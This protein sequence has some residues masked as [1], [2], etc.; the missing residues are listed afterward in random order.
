MP[1]DRSRPR[2]RPLQTLC[3]AIWRIEHD[4]GLLQRKVA[5]VYY[6]PLIRAR[7]IDVLSQRLGFMDL[8][9][10]QLRRSLPVAFLREIS[11]AADDLALSPWSLNG[12]FDTIVV[13]FGRKHLR[14]GRLVDGYSDRVFR[15]TEFGR[16]LVLDGRA[17][18]GYPLQRYS[19]VLPHELRSRDLLRTLALALA[20]VRLPRIAA[21]ASRELAVIGEGLRKELSIP[22][23]MSVAHFALRIAT[24]LEGRALWTSV[25]AKSGARIVFFTGSHTLTGVAAAALDLGLKTVEFQHGL[26]S[27]YQGTYHYPGRP[28][29][30]YAPERLLTFG[31]YWADGLD[32]PANTISTPIGVEDRA[33]GA[34]SARITRRVLIPSQWSIGRKLFELVRDTAR[35][36]PDWEFVYRPHPLDNPAFYR[37][38]LASR[39][40]SPPNLRLSPIEEDIYTLMESSEVQIGL[41][42]TA[43][44]EGMTLGLRTIIVDLPGVENLDRVLANGDAVLARDADDI[45]AAL[46]TAPVARR[47]ERYFEAPVPSIA[48]VVA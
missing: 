25:L 47:P 29:V 21:E 45:V 44:F 6:W 39:T 27:S 15:E 35:R 36:A 14:A 10:P 28:T 40:S 20:T 30:P 17:P 41:Y 42:S 23:P 37:E 9:Q 32:L 2:T 4:L 24:F 3:E 5:G 33:H 26:I 11:A 12:K 16:C 38:Q 13:P 22:C 31:A 19:V 1:T 46:P 43:L 48:A 7:M 8:P 34:T 18:R